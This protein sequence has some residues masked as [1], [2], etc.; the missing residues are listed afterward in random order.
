MN[1]NPT[2][3]K[4][5]G[6]EEQIAGNKPR[7]WPALLT[8]YFLSPLIGEMISGSTP[9]LLFIQPFSLIFLPLLYGSSAILIHE[10]MV[11]RHLGWGNAL[12]LG[13]AFGIF[14]EA[15][16]VQTWFNFISP[17]SPTHDLGLYGVWLGTN[18]FWGLGLTLYHSLVSITIP[19]LLIE[20]FFPRRVRITWLSPAGI[21]GFLVWLLLPCALLALNVATRQFAAD[22]YHGPPLGPYLFTAGLTAALVVLGSFIRLPLQKQGGPASAPSLWTV[23]LS[24]FGL[25]VGDF[26]IIGQLLPRLGLPAALVGGLELATFGF[27]LWRVNTWSARPGWNERHT[28]AII[29]GVLAFYCFIFAPLVEFGVRIPQRVGMTL[30]DL[31]VLV[32]LIV[33]DRYLVRRQVRS[34]A[35]LT[36]SGSDGEEGG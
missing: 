26:L 21:A 28:M 1:P 8:L 32:G 24:I 27:G 10:V 35:A 30:T 29:M 2:R 5:I 9:F 36:S 23:R 22:G 14:Q 12:I 25:V 3:S 13:A 33:F 6:G 34:P 11:R 15:L 7:T 17:H 16:V 31:I 18:W 20:L 4:R 19:L